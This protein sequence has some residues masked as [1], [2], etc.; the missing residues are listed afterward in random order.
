MSR[1]LHL[2]ILEE[3]KAALEEANVKRFR[4]YLKRFD[5]GAASPSK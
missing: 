4:K 1:Q 2:I 5:T 3:M